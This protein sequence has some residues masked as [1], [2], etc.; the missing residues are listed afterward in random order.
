MSLDT[1]LASVTAGA[2]LQARFDVVQSRALAAGAIGLGLSLVGGLIW[3]SSVLPAYLVAVLFWTGISLG[4]IGLTLIHH[5]AGG[6]WALP[7]RR[8]FEAGAMAIVVMAVLST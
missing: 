8:P 3:P 2:D 1:D 7:L 6:S 5:L 4:S